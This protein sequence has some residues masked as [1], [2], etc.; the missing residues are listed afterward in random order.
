MRQLPYFGRSV[1]LTYLI[2]GTCHRRR[3]PKELEFFVMAKRYN[4]E[5]RKVRRIFKKTD[6]RCFYC[7][8]ELPPDTDNKDDLGLVVSSIRNWHIDH[9]IPISRGGDNNDDNLVPACRKC[10]GDKSNK[11]ADEFTG[12]K[13]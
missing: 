10:N 3:T 7:G 12:V 8:I 6:G 2:T 5:Y 11:T 9:V 4:F 13:Q 1:S